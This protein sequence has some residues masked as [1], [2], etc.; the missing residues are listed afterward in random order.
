MEAGMTVRI[1]EVLKYLDTEAIKYEYRG[2]RNIE[3]SRFCPLNNLKK[4]AITWVRHIGDAKA[5]VLNAVGD[6]VLVAEYGQYLEA[7]EIP[8]IYA[9]NAHRAFFMILS[10]FFGDKDPEAR[11]PNIAPTAVIE[12]EKIGRGVYVGHHTYIGPGVEVGDK[13]AILNNVTIQGR[14]KIGAFTVIES[15]TTIGV[16]GF[17]HYKGDDGK[18]YCVPH[19]GGVVIGSYVKIGANNTISRGCL[20]D[21]VIGDYVKTDNLCHI[22]HNAHIKTG[23]MLTACV[24]ISGSVTVGEHVWLG[25]GTVVNNGVELGDNS[26]TGLGAAI[27]KSQPANKVIVGVP[28]RVLRERRPGE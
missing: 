1:G 9:V 4:G 14:V 28:G 16:C 10:K 5:D 20:D 25:P 17:G 19:L 26:Y 22:A 6:I 3:F 18:P 7:A 13:T 15:G 24:E 8:V 23:A 12:T 27:T 11:V 2:D 21:T